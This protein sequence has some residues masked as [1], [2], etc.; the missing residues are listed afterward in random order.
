MTDGSK[1]QE[2]GSPGSQANADPPTSRPTG[3]EQSSDAP[4]TASA[5][6]Q[7]S[8]GSPKTKPSGVKRWASRLGR[9]LLGG[10]LPGA[11]LYAALFGL[12]IWRH[13]SVEYMGVE[14]DDTASKVLALFEEE[15][16]SQQLE[17]LALYLG[18]GA[19]V[20]L[21]GYGW[22]VLFRYVRRKPS[23]SLWRQAPLTIAVSALI[24]LWFLVRS[25]Y[26]YPQLYAPQADNSF[27]LDLGFTLGVDVVQP[28]FVTLVAVLFWL[29]FGGVALL[30]LRQSYLERFP[31][32]LSRGQTAALAASLLCGLTAGWA[33]FAASEELAA[34]RPAAEKRPNILLIAVD[35]LRGDV[36][37]DGALTPNIDRFALQGT[38]FTHAFTVMPRTFPAWAT[39][40]TGQYPHTHGIRHMFPQP[41]THDTIEGTV[42]QQLSRAGYR[43]AVFSDH[44]GDVFTRA[45]FGF[46][47]VDAPEFTLKSNV[48]L[49]G[50]KL[51]V[52][53]MPY[54]VDVLKGAWTP[55]LMANERLGDPA[56]LTERALS[57]IAGDGQPVE[58]REKPFFATVFYSA[59]HF[60]FASPAPFYRKYTDPQYR[61][62]SRF[63]KEAYAKPLEGE[64]RL[65]EERHLRH[66]FL[67]A[68][69]ASDH[70]IGDL[71][72]RLDRAGMLADSLV[73]ITADHGENLYEHGLGVGHGDH[74]YGLA[75]LHVP[76]I[77]RLPPNLERTSGGK[78]RWVSRESVRLVDIAPTIMAQTKL[79]SKVPMEGVDLTPYTRATNKPLS[80]LPAFAETGL[81]FYP[82]ETDRLE[83]KMIRFASG[84]E[85]FRP[86]PET[87]KIYL[88][89]SFEE[90]AVMAKHRML[91]EN[92]RKLLYI[93][94]RDGVR[95]EMYD[96]YRDPGE[97]Q[98]LVEREPQRFAEMKNR[99]LEWM[100]RDPQMVRIGDYVLPRGP[101]GMPSQSPA[102]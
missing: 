97:T 1:A 4:T 27:V 6:P 73:I 63:H 25:A 35:S 52:H 102:Q 44:A 21:V 98:N 58:D 48:R 88:D 8:I 47:H 50:L 30:A 77:V 99:L 66:L 28:W 62:R 91:L 101:L 15:V 2:P 31:G 59:G 22:T 72:K 24:H 55:E 92:D 69:A 14:D 86:E 70:A 100:L 18:I 41:G 53:L 57:W 51:H 34:T 9:P 78:R 90:T 61:G 56:W 33:S 68:L 65:A 87:W 11:T 45:D 49:G 95:W 16:I 82:P 79:A 81:W 40:L 7:T 38:R 60:P 10:A 80:S 75:A 64:A 76:L 32:S 17:L 67:G 74:L 19:V 13:R 20:G 96:P 93:P 85:A 71:L 54:I 84:F 29:S 43:T 26:T 37:G 12:C 5:G 39:I 42:A 46:Q 89:P 36:V 94:T 23:R 83:G 3:S